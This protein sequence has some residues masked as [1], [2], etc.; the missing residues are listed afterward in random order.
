MSKKKDTGDK[1]TA[2]ITG[3]ISGQVAVGK[4]IS[5]VQRITKSTE[6]TKE[7]LD[8]LQGLF[9]SLRKEVVE[10]AAPDKK[11]SALE[12]V[13]E[14]EQAVISEKPDISTMEYVQ[15]WFTKNLP[16]IAGGVTSIVINPIVGKLVEAGG[17]ALIN[18]FKR[19]FGSTPG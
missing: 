16:S 12:R 11:D 10:Q 8:E 19:R 15:N 2:N 3:D 17:D 7:E 14:L 5:Q 13:E 6:V 9:S 18:E 1:I 4:N